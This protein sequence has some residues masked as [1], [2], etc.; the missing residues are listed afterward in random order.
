MLA[1]G[2]SRRMGTDKAGLE[3]VSR[4]HGVTTISRLVLR[5]LGDVFP[6]VLVIG[7]DPLP[8]EGWRQCADLFPGGGA[9]GG[10]YT[11]LQQA[12][13]EYVFVAACDMPFLSPGAAAAL[14]EL[15]AGHDVTV[16]VLD[17]RAQT[18]HAVYRKTCAAPALALLESG[19]RRIVDFYPAVDVREVPAAEF[20]LLDPG[21]Q[22]ARN[23]NTPADLA[24][25]RLEIGGE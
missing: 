4:E 3:I 2:Q 19:R 9:L 15:A 7:G 16:P 17:G 11:A 24:R 10:I 23:V 1:G 18:L 22:S 21:G 14:L 5:A 20:A 13:H 6:E 8:G 25:A 12:R